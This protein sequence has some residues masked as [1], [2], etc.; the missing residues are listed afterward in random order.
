MYQPELDVVVRVLDKKLL[1]AAARSVGMQ[2]PETWFPETDADVARVAR[3][4]RMPVL[5][6]PRTQV[7]TATPTK[8]IVVSRPEDLVLRY[9][10]FVK[11]THYGKALL[12]RVP[13]AAN[14]MIQQYVSAAA[15]QNLRA[16][17]VR[18]S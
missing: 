5:I 9:R 1:Y 3:E 8:G 18:R 7:L 16:R 6:K 14:A 11:S 13:D 17:G 2:V 15:D 4:A 10:E 12:D